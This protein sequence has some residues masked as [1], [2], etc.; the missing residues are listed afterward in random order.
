MLKR[1]QRGRGEC[2]RQRRLSCYDPS[3]TVPSF[4]SPCWFVRIT[5][6]S[7]CRLVVVWSIE[8]AGTCIRKG[9]KR[10]ALAISIVCPLL[11]ALLPLPLPTLL[12]LLASNSTIANQVESAQG[13]GCYKK[14][15]AV[16]ALKRQQSITASIRRLSRLSLSF[17]SLDEESLIL[18]VL[19]RPP[20]PSILLS[21]H[22]LVLPSTHKLLDPLPL[23]LT[24]SSSPFPPSSSPSPPS[25]SSPL[26]LH[27][28]LVGSFLSSRTL[29]SFLSITWR[30]FSTHLRLLP[31][32]AR[33][34]AARAA[35]TRVVRMAGGGAGGNV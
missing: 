30:P 25:S 34:T 7:L 14:K 21:L 1:D 9:S 28:S 3:P 11:S 12:L 18:V 24:P 31:P 23:L 4:S 33:A 2:S 10:R 32:P 35:R 27:S 26:S 19:H 8:E 6:E 13:N 15:R 5:I 20:V 29:P 22:F 16:A 17:C